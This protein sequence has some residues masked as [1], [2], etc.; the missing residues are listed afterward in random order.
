[1]ATVD[2]Y[3]AERDYSRFYFVEFANKYVVS[4]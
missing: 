4:N 2:T 3:I 1:M